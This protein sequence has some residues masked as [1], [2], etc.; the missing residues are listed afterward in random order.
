MNDSKSTVRAIA[1]TLARKTRPEALALGDAVVVGNRAG[2]VEWTSD[3]WSRLTGFPLSDTLDKPITH[4]L[5]CAGIELE[6]VEFVAQHFLAGR[7][8][9]VELPFETFD[10]RRIEVHLE[11]DPLRDSNGEISRF[12][13]VVSD[14]SARKGAETSLSISALGTTEPALEAPRRSTSTAE[15]SSAATPASERLCLI[16]AA[17]RAIRRAHAETADHI[18][19]DSEFAT[20]VPKVQI[21]PNRF[22]ALMDSMFDAVLADIDANPTFITVLIG[23][24]EPG[25]SHRSRAHPVPTRAMPSSGEPQAYLE[26]HDTRPHLDPA[27]L[28]RIQ[29]GETPHTRR[30]EALQLAAKLARANGLALFSDSTPG[31]GNQLLLVV[32]PCT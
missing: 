6:L 19:F 10:R 21:D 11:V 32:S 22:D 12:V 15:A 2:V 3:A 1:E 24:L 31:C 8:S 28:M 29:D 23:R 5:T 30:E 17:D 25:L 26:I 16:D 13:A 18:F 20:D 7:S 27:A 9:T 4:F 14:I